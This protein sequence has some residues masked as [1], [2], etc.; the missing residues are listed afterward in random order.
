MSLSLFKV[1]R[2]EW[3]K[4]EAYS[5]INTGYLKRLSLSNF[6]APHDTNINSFRR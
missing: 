6:L 5:K 2:R 1:L 3:Q 4:I